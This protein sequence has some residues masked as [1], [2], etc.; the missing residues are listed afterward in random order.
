MIEEQAINELENEKEYE[1]KENQYLNCICAWIEYDFDEEDEYL[2]EREE[3]E[4][5]PSRL[6]GNFDFIFL[7][8]NNLLTSKDGK[9]FLDKEEFGEFI[10]NSVT[11]TTGWCHNGFSYKLE[12]KDKKNESETIRNTLEE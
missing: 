7:T 3:I 12:V 5:P 8:N 9:F 11:D 6:E 2:F 1:I 4:R 10:N